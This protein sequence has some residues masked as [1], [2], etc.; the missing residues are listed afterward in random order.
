M[1]DPA[2][3]IQFELVRAITQSTA[4][5]GQINYEYTSLTDLQKEQAGKA[6]D[7]ILKN[8]NMPFDEGWRIMNRDLQHIASEF[9][10][11]PATLFCV[12]MDWI[13]RNKSE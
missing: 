12:Y 8:H 9:L 6:I 11:D 5:N 2:K 7:V 4:S 13:S 3:S 1:E 10:I